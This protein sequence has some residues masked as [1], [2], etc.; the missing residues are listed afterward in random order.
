ML[1]LSSPSR[2][3]FIRIFALFFP[4]N[5]KTLNPSPHIDASAADG[6]LK[7]LRQK[8]KLLKPLF[9][10]YTYIYRAFSCFFLD[11]FNVVCYR[12]VVCGKRV[13]IV[14]KYRPYTIFSIRLLTKHT[15]DKLEPNMYK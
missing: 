4:H 2:L 6:F 8:K 10:N 9:S 11:T 14:L 7:T 15:R 1:V 5:G 3:L 13:N 12:F